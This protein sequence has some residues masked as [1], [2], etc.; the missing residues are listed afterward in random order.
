MDRELMHAFCRR[1]PFKFRLNSKQVSKLATLQRFS[2]RTH[3]L[4]GC[5]LPPALLHQSVSTITM[6]DCRLNRTR[7]LNFQLSKMDK[8]LFMYFLM[9]RGIQNWSDAP[10]PQI[11]SRL[12]C[13]RTSASETRLRASGLPLVRRRD[14]PEPRPFLTKTVAAVAGENT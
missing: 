6:A 1:L 13:R 4:R 10:R 8:C 7:Q 12:W 14:S 2:Q 5:V 3:T 9:Q 11:R